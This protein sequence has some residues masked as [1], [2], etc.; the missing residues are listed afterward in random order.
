[1]NKHKKS[2]RDLYNLLDLPGNNLLREAQEELDEA[3]YEVYGLID[4]NNPLK[5]LLEL[6]KQ[7]H[8]NEING[9]IISGPGLP[10]SITHTAEYITKDCISPREH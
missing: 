4:K 1:M 2:L 8:T 5:F 6:N 10:K 3:V 7:L 9:Q